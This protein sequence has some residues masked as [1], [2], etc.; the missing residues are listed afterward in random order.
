MGSEGNLL[1]ISKVWESWD[2]LPAADVVGYVAIQGSKF[3]IDLITENRDPSGIRI[4]FL[5]LYTEGASAHTNNCVH[6][7]QCDADVKIAVVRV[8]SPSTWHVHAR[9]HVDGRVMLEA[10]YYPIPYS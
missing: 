5:L 8:V 4:R 10:G 7:S 3:N 2:A 6:E 1:V 9:V